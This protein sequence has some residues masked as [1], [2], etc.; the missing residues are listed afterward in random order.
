MYKEEVVN[1]DDVH[2]S[3]QQRRWTGLHHLGSFLGRSESRPAAFL[4][5]ISL[6][7]ALTR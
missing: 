2:P 1:E 5:C 3:R 4:L 6:S 7:G